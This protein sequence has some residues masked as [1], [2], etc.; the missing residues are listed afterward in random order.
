MSQDSNKV[1][2]SLFDSIVD[3]EKLQEK[4]LECQRLANR[5]GLIKK[6]LINRDLFSLD[7]E[8]DQRLHELIKEFSIRIDD[9]LYSTKA[10]S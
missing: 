10:N 8:F 7:L 6:I 5:V 9:E 1:K 4:E 3:N 2:K